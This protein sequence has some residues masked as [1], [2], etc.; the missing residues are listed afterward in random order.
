MVGFENNNYQLQERSDSYEVSVKVLTPPASLQRP[1]NV[2]VHTVSGT[3]LGNELSSHSLDTLAQP[4]SL[5]HA[6][7]SD[8]SL[9]SSLLTLSPSSPLAN[10][11]INIPQDGIVL[12]DNETFAL[13][14]SHAGGQ[15]AV[16]LRNATVVIVDTDGRCLQNTH[17]CDITNVYTTLHY[18]IL[19]VWLA[20]MEGRVVIHQTTYPL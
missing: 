14:L 11:T 5:C 16:E 6:D 9:G 1:I 12:E 17:Y 15:P 13:T 10:Q 3:A 8:Y 2:S 20:I 19:P 4:Q 7:G 18:Q